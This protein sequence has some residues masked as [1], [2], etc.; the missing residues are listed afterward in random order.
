MT[1]YPNSECDAHRDVKTSAPVCIICMGNEI[2]QL[3][4]QLAG[5]GVAAMQNTKESIKD[6]A[7]DGD[8]GYSAHPTPMSAKL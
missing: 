1:K 4:V 5:C 3:R 6:R 7:V 2:E 8:Y